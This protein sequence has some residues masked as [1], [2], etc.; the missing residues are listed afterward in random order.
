VR[1]PLRRLKIELTL[2]GLLFGTIRTSLFVANVTGRVQPPCLNSACASCG[3]ADAKTSAGAP[4][5]ICS[6][7]WLEPAK[8]Y[9]GLGSICV[10]TSR[11]EDAA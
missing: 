10:N 11:N 4:R 9:V 7:S 1:P 2:P 3:L 5:S 8:L 6:C